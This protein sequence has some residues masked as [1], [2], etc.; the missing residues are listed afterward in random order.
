[1]ED[2][3]LPRHFEIGE[4]SHF[5]HGRISDKDDQGKIP[6]SA[7]DDGSARRHRQLRADG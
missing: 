1:M 5:A 4:R 2:W 7:P 3:I 6:R